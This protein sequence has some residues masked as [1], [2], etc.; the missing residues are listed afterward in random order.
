VVTERRLSAGL[1]ADSDDDG[2]NEFDN[3]ELTVR[4]G[5][6]GENFCLKGWGLGSDRRGGRRTIRGPLR[7]RDSPFSAQ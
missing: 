4:D 3:T 2:A 1:S 7:G 6:T 5:A